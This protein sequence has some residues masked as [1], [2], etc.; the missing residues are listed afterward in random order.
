MLYDVMIDLETLSV[1]PDASILVI[2]AIKFPRRGYLRSIND[3]DTFYRRITQKSC[4]EVGLRTDETTLDWWKTQ[5]NDIRYEALENPDRVELKQALLEFSDWIATDTYCI[6]GNGDDFDCTILSEAYHRCGLQVP[7]KFWNTRDCRTI[8]DIANIGI[9]DLLQDN[10]HH[11][12]FDCYRQ[13]V[14]V[15]LA[16][17]KLRL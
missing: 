8:F 5:N 10:K 9:Q 17:K 12:L 15:R 1:R 16:L 7:W 4:I 6:W 2:G 11:A 14:G 13:I 3:L